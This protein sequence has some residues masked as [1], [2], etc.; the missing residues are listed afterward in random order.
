M[1]HNEVVYDQTGGE[2]YEKTR[3]HDEKFQ[4]YHCRSPFCFSVR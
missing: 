2:C 4:D 1:A 3:T